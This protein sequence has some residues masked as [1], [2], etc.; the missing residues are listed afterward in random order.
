MV[1][2]VFAF[3]V[4]GIW[5]YQVWK[6]FGSPFHQPASA[7]SAIQ[8]DLTGWFYELSKRPA[9]LLFFS[10]GVLTLTPFFSFLFLTARQFYRQVSDAIFPRP[11]KTPGVET[12]L[13]AWGLVFYVFASEPWHLFSV[14]ATQEHRFFYMAYPALAVLSAAGFDHLRAWGRGRTKQGWVFDLVA[15]VFLSLNAWWGIPPAMK[16]ILNNS[17]LF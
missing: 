14:V 13:W 12:V 15:L 2:A 1:F 6:V 10:W 8:N 17:M 3:L 16:F 5:F 11:V 9:P 4:S 7:E